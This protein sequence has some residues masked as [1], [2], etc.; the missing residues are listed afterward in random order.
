M[1]HKL[2][3]IVLVALVVKIILLFF[4]NYDLK[5]NPDEEHNYQIAYNHQHGLGYT[6]YVPEIN[7]YKQTSFHGSFPVF[8]Y[9]FLLKN[10][11]KKDE[12]QNKHLSPSNSKRTRRFFDLRSLGA[13]SQMSSLDDSTRKEACP[14][15]LL[16]SGGSQ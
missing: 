2:N 3:I 4:T 1:N 6:I 10:D 12:I 16:W 14:R 15:V 11:I 5:M 9:E 7:T 8:I 13:L